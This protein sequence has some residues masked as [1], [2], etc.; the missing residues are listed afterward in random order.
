MSTAVIFDALVPQELRATGQAL[1]LTVAFG[2]A[3]VVGT[4]L[5]GAVFERLGA[6]ALF[7]GAAATSAAGMIVAWFACAGS[8]FSRRG[9]AA[10]PEGV[11][12]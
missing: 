12:G 4:A 7:L 10:V 9:R 6:P 8:Q 5:G 2:V 1:R 3:P 11:E